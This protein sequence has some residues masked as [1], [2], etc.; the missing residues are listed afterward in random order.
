MMTIGPS[1]S[2][3]R[4]A[5]PGMPA[6]HE[7]CPTWLSVDACGADGGGRP[8]GGSSVVAYLDRSRVRHDPQATPAG[9]PGGRGCPPRGGRAPCEGIRTT[10][11]FVAE[12]DVDVDVAA[13]EGH[14]GDDAGAV[15][16]WREDDVLRA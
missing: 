5:T 7:P 6:H 12:L 9:T 3:V 1:T 11:R 10:S 8:A 16:D 14:V 4:Y 2:A 15:G 13:D